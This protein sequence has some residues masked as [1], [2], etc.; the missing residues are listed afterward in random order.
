MDPYTSDYA[1]RTTNNANIA[2]LCKERATGLLLL[3]TDI[4]IEYLRGDSLGNIYRPFLD[5]ILVAFKS[6]SLLPMS[7]FWRT[8]RVGA[9]RLAS[10]VPATH[11]LRISSRNQ[12]PCYTFAEPQRQM[13]PSS[14][15]RALVTTSDKVQE[16][17]VNPSYYLSCL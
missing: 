17:A 9:L 12:T 8:C 10:Q 3:C 14:G 5:P 1:S 6:M 2:M 16:R 13:S 15:Y 11:V 7:L 4:S